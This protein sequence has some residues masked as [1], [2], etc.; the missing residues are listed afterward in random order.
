MRK[1][2]VLLASV[3]LILCAVAVVGGAGSASA[4]STT[5]NQG[6][7]ATTIRVGIPYVD[8]ATVR[9]FGI[10]LNQGSFPDAYN[11]L[12]SNLNARGGINGRRLVPYLVAVNPVGTAPANTACT[13]LAE[14][15]NVF[16]ALAPQ[17]ADCFL[18]QYH[19][20]TIAG[21]FQN[22]VSSGAPNFTL[23]PPLAA[24]DPL[25]LS[26]FAHRGVFKGKQ[27]GLFAGDE[28]DGPELHVVESALKSL[29]VHVVKSA[30]DGAPSGDEA[31][32]YQQAD[33]ITQIFQSAGVNEVV[34]VGTGATIWPESLQANQ[35]TFSP[36]WIAT[37]EP[38]LE[39]AVLGSSIPPKLLKNVLTSSPVPSNYQ[40][41]HTPAVQQCAQVVRK[42]YPSDQM[43]PPTNPLTGSNQSFYAVE[44]ACVNLALFET[45]AKAAGK[46]LTF[47]SF[48]HAGYELRDT[49]IA[50]A[51]APV[52]FGPG[53]AYAL[54]PVYLVTYDSAD[55]ELLFSDSPVAI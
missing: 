53:R 43:T 48:A 20:P 44:S 28:A 22:V 52:S 16:V 37:S 12:I 10:T 51:G 17:Q 42:A 4:G 8:L 3:S 6:V 38:S 11:A 15:D 47:S 18:Q 19:L 31:A 54:G 29:G 41:W 35:S 7:A 34:A 26:V 13:Q 24:Y 55:N 39:G 50:G 2:V 40:I 33:I 36:P 21:S 5:P 32:I 30:V 1:C 27:V 23:E 25:Q 49:A 9:Q 45:I 46:N 14:N